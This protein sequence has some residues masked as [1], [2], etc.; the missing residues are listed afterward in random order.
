MYKNVLYYEK[1]GT[2]KLMK[3][4]LIMFVENFKHI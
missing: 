4:M 2:S 1:A 3:I